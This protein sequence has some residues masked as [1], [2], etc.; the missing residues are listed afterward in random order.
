[1]VK[2]VGKIY[3]KYVLTI[4]ENRNRFESMNIKFYM[5]LLVFLLV[6]C[7][8]RDTPIQK[9]IIEEKREVNNSKEIL[10][11]KYQVIVRPVVEAFIRNDKDEIINLIW[12]PLRRAYPIPS[13][14]NKQEMIERYDQVF[15]ENIT[16][17]IKNSSIENSWTDV[18]WRG[19][20]LD[21][22]SVWIDEYDG[23]ITSINYQSLQEKEMRN[24]IINEMKNNL[25]ESL[26]EFLEPMLLCETDNYVI[27]I[28]FM[29]D[30]SHN[31]RLAVWNKGKKQ[32]ESPDII[33]TN[34]EGIPDG[35]GG[36]FIC[37]FI[38]DNIQ[39]ILWVDVMNDITGRSYG[40]FTML[41]GIEKHWYNYNQENILLKEKI[42]KIE[43]N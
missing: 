14:N 34:G 37:L 24:N 15:D 18:G 41:N 13:I 11:E 3:Q 40:D 31:L 17:M 26:K 25:H 4:K 7:Q 2:L 38:H 22:G 8:N 10:H 19:I 39:Y 23:K 21:N 16:N 30:H 1:V 33:L 35:S 27:R 43:P 6:S 12:Y 29:H 5:I 32:N 42:T 9:E 28:D 36:N 20:M